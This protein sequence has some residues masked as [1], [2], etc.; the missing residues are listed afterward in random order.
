MPLR[1]LPRRR[2]LAS[3]LAA[4]PQRPAEPCRRHSMATARS[5]P[6]PSITQRTTIRLGCP[7]HAHPAL[8]IAAR[9]SRKT[10]GWKNLS[11]ARLY[12]RSTRSFRS[13][14]AAFRGPA[15]CYFWVVIACPL[16]GLF[17]VMIDGGP[18]YFALLVIWLLRDGLLDIY[19]P[20]C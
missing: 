10:A 19:L 15:Q 16:S 17:Y 6:V 20:S 3:S 2:T 18:A 14:S 1:W 5:R 8:G 11:V 7:A 12:I 9:S 4:R 13:L